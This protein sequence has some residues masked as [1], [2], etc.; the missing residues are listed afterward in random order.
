MGG[1]AVKVLVACEY[2]GAV[3]D[4]F[5]AA[6]HDATSCDLLP[7]DAPGPHY[8]GDVRHIL[9]DGWDLMVAHPPCTY[10]ALSGVRWLYTQPLRWQD[11]IDGAVFFRA[12][13]EAPIERIAVENPIMHNWAARIVGQKQAQIVQ[14]WMFGHPERKGTGLWLKNLPRLNPT[15]DVRDEMATLTRQQ[16]HRIHHL[17]PTVDRWKLRSATFPGLAAAM[18]DQWGSPDLLSEVAA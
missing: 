11:L 10:L 3:R 18:A 13:L 17:S 14:P 4:A 9:R 15:N 7:T 12:L 5:I 2:S 1:K 16:Q 8:Q 6:G